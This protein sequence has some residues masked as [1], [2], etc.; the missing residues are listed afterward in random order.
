MLKLLH[1]DLLFTPGLTHAFT[2]R[3]GG[4][5]EGAYASLN[6]TRSRGDKPENVAI[7]RN[8][9]RD[10]LGLDYLAFATQVHGCDV[11]RV[12]EAPRGEQ[13]AGEAD[14][15]ITN[16]PGIG[17]VA[18]TADCTPI[19]L[20]DPENRAVAAI[21]SGWRSTVKN[22][23]SETIK[24]MAEAY[25]T[26]PQDLK[27]AIG[28]SVS[29]AHYRVGPEVVAQFEQ[30]EA[31]SGVLGPRDGDGGAQLDVA[32]AC[33]LQLR[34]AGVPQAQI[35]RSSLCTYAEE[36]DLFSARRSHHR[37]ETGVFGGQGGVIGLRRD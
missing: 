24:A 30:F 20:F 13:P 22:I 27:A 28:P 5:S 2:T 32:L 16:Q 11:V 15:M 21:H 19:L 6:I 12:D 17:L 23:V 9:V 3:H 18:Q 26:K 31:Q 8:R 25:G 7:N 1:A 10:A 35:D 33:A 34:A 37:G 36:A 29:P 14:A 4:V